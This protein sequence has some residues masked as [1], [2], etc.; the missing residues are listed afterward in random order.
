MVTAKFRSRFACS[1]QCQSREGQGKSTESS[2]IRMD[3]WSVRRKSRKMVATV[4]D[5]ATS[6]NGFPEGNTL[7]CDGRRRRIDWGQDKCSGRWEGRK[8]GRNSFHQWPPCPPIHSHKHKH[9]EG[10]GAGGFWGEIGELGKPFTPA[11]LCLKVEPCLDSQRTGHA[12]EPIQAQVSGIFTS[13]QSGVKNTN[14]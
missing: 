12:S 8:E 2:R 6:F 4:R 13:A 3:C 11:G 1:R 7:F 5:V 14:F 10:R 9:I